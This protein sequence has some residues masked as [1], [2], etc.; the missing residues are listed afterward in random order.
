[1]RKGGRWGASRRVGHTKSGGTEGGT[2]A[3]GPLYSRDGGRE[4]GVGG[5]SWSATRRCRAGGGDAA[6]LRVE[7]G[8]GVRWVGVRYRR[9]PHGPVALGRPEGIV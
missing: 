2:A 6:L 3:T 5:P 1:M 9:G 8:E 4:D 7:A